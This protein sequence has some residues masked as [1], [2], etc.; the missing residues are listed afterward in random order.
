MSLFG[1]KQ[2]APIV[3]FYIWIKCGWTAYEIPI[4]WTKIIG[5]REFQLNP[6]VSVQVPQSI[7]L[8]V[9]AP[10]KS[11]LLTTVGVTWKPTSA[12]HEYHKQH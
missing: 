11:K 9:S 7:L 6:M 4:Q 2:Y 3:G 5:F 1:H 12:A 10:N 8:I